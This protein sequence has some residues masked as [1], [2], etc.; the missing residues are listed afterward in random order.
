MNQEE[1]DVLMCKAA[2]GELSARER[3]EWEVLCASRPA[4][5]EE[6][7][8]L[9]E[10]SESL[11]AMVVAAEESAAREVPDEV[12]PYMLAELEAARKELFP[13]APTGRRSEGFSFARWFRSGTA[14]MPLAA[15]AAIVIGVGAIFV[16]RPDKGPDSLA[17][18][19][20]LFKSEVVSPDLP[21]VSPGTE[22]LLT[23]PD[24]IWVSLSR[25]PV[26]IEVLDDK[27]QIVISGR[28]TSAPAAWK[29][30]A[31][32]GSSVPELTPG[33]KYLVRLVQGGVKSERVID[34]LAQAKGMTG[35]L[36][37]ERLRKLA[38][39]WIDA[40]R[41]ADALCLINR[42][43][44]RLKSTGETP[45]ADLV[46]LRGKAFETALAATRTEMR[47]KAIGGRNN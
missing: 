16:F 31:A 22:T 25:E 18:I 15:A 5:L 27:E 20:P 47:E 1:M 41:A 17:V 19:P 38:E 34:V 11:K 2:A 3:A 40:G 23:T 32:V 14:W 44:G 33:R 35:D 37:G 36:E 46:E 43:L 39:E 24:F 12:P 7:A 10:C 26:E 45:A 28:A 29:E 6:M 30:L 8:A 9:R 42:E 4:L 21:V 13:A